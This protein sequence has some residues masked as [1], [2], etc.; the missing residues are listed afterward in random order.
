MGIKHIIV[1]ISK[2]DC[3]LY[4][5]ARYNEIKESVSEHLKI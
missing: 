2:M 3:V 5:E 4:D 1:A